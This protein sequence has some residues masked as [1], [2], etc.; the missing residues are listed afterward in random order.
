MIDISSKTFFLFGIS[1]HSWPGRKENRISIHF[2]IKEKHSQKNKEDPRNLSNVLHWKVSDLKHEMQ[3]ISQKIECKMCLRFTSITLLCCSL[4]VMNTT[5][6]VN[7]SIYQIVLTIFLFEFPVLSAKYLVYLILR[8]GWACLPSPCTPH[9]PLLCFKARPY[10]PGDSSTCHKEE[11]VLKLEHQQENKEYQQWKITINK[12]LPAFPCWPA[13]CLCR[14]P[15]VVR[16]VPWL[17]RT[18][19]RWGGTAEW[20]WGG[21]RSSCCPTSTLL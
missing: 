17:A 19:T 11:E 20:G 12:L 2:K 6:K 16:A 9:K 10:S 5:L 8:M 13:Q 3:Q 18:R 7:P 1:C 15:P 14:C 4:V 21:C